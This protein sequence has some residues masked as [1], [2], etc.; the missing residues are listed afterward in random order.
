MVFPLKQVQVRV[1]RMNYFVVDGISA[2]QMC[3]AK[4]TV[5]VSVAQVIPTPTLIYLFIFWSGLY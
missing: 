1:V 2:V 4:F 3:Y 5:K